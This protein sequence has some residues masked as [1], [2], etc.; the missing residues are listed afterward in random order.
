MGLA[1]NIDWSKGEAAMQDFNYQLLQMGIN[2]DESSAEWQNMLNA[3]QNMNTSVVHRDLDS[4]RAQ[5][6]EINNIAQNVEM[7]S[8]ISDEDY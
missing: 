4:I 2:V 8:I 1:N 3:M 6:V 5:I 7:G